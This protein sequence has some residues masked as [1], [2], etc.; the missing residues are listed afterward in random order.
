MAG[1]EELKSE[2]PFKAAA[3][4][5]LSSREGYSK[6]FCLPPAP[7]PSRGGLQ[8]QAGIPGHSFSP[9]LHQEVAEGKTDPARSL[10]SQRLPSAWLPSANLE[11]LEVEIGVERYF[12]IP[13]LEGQP[14]PGPWHQAA[15]WGLSY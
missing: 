4:P 15:A 12:S 7:H 3:S 6:H 9:Y 5:T 11:S 10:S 1:L 2:A 14:T 8:R 13:G